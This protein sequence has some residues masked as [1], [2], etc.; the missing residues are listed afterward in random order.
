MIS[1]LALLFAVLTDSMGH[2]KKARFASPGQD[3]KR[4]VVSR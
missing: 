1:A 2:N 4:A 3:T